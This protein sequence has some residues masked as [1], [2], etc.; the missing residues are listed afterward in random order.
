MEHRL[1][2][3]IKIIR[4]N[5]RIG[6]HADSGCYPYDDRDPFFIESCPHVY[7][8]GNQ[9]EYDTRLIKG[10][11]GQVV[12]LI[13]IPRFAEIGVVVVRFANSEPFSSDEIDEE[14]TPWASYF[15]EMTQ[16]I[17]DT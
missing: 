11:E 15:L 8:L 14:R 5:Q 16:S 9:D 7:F 1:K 3:P 6:Y 2:R 13:C 4:A 10:S 17:N 12:R